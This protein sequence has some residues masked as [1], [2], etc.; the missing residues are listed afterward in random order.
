MSKTVLLF[1]GAGASTAVNADRYPTTSQFFDRLPKNVTSSPVFTI[2]LEYL[3]QSQRDGRVDVE[4]VL[5]TLGELD[6]FLSHMS[7]SATL[8]HWLLSKGK[9]AA[10]VNKSVDVRPV[11]GLASQIHPAAAAVR[12]SI[13]AQVYDLY[14]SPPTP[15]E[16]RVTWLPLLEAALGH[17]DRVELFTTNYDLVLEYAI[18]EGKLPISDGRVGGTLR[19]TLDVDV[20]SRFEERKHGLLTKLHGSVDWSRQGTAILVGNPLYKGDHRRHVIIY[21]GFK[22][23]PA[24][25]P[26]IAFHRHLVRVARAAAAV[27]FV[28][29]AFRDQHVNELLTSAVR[30]RTPILVINP[31]EHLDIPFERSSALEHLSKRFDEDTALY[32]A[33]WLLDSAGAT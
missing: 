31:E 11:V 19:P 8:A 18:A 14:A 30:P 3:K 27:L 32:A 21:P 13:N 33:G 26:F 25:E 7:D 29:F 9:Y 5:W 1:A 15:D 17:F 4:Q 20:W 12:D 2:L 6:E 28:G 22:G 10:L 23:A 16:L 24:A